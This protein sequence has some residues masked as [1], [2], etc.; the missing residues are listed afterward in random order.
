MCRSSPP[1]TNTIFSYE[2]PGLD[3]LAFLPFLMNIGQVFAF[4]DWDDQDLTES[5]GSLS[6]E[7]EEDYGLFGEENG[8]FHAP[9]SLATGQHP[10]T[11]SETQDFWNEFEDYERQQNV[12]RGLQP[13]LDDD[14]WRRIFERFSNPPF[15]LSGVFG[16]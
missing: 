6:G 8:E 3:E 15:F 2:T 1:Q 12:W 13:P 14:D 5:E 11:T 9:S 4:Q 10:D 7:V 16:P